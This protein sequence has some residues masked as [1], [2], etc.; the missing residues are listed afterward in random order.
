[1]PLPPHDDQSY[2]IRSD[3]ES[4]QKTGKIMDKTPIF[5][6]KTGFYPY[7]QGTEVQRYI[8]SVFS[9]YIGDI[10]TLI[11]LY[12]YLLFLLI[13]RVQRYKVYAEGVFPLYIVI[14]Q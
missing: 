2:H 6:E 7:F 13:S 11:G 1:M 12:L 14:I 9:L 8:P 5:S 3:L 10:Y 4:T